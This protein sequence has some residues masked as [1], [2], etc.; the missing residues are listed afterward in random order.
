MDTREDRKQRNLEANRLLGRRLASIR[1]A[2]EVTQAEVA[3]ALG[4]GRPLVSKI[5][6]GTRELSATEIPAYAAAI[7]STPRELLEAIVES[8]ACA[9]PDE[10]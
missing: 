10:G 8:V 5:E 7:G 4:F 9:T 3:E 6:G 1:M 2:N